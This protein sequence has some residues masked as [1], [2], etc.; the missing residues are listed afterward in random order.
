MIVSL[1]TDFGLSDEYAGLMKAVIYS[2]NADA[3]VVDLSHHV[4]AHDVAAASFLLASSYPFFP[5]GT[6]HVAVVDPGVG[7]S[8]RILAAKHNGHIFLAPD[9]GLL[10]VPL[11]EGRTELMV[12]VSNQSYF[13]KEQSATFHGRDIFAPVAAYLTRGVALDKLG[14]PMQPGKMIQLPG[15]L[16]SRRGKTIVGRVVAVDRFGNLVTNIPA[17]IV[18]DLV[19]ETGGVSP[20]V[21]VDG[22][23]VNGFY[24]SYGQAPENT[25]FVLVGSRGTLEVAVRERSAARHL[26]VEAGAMVLVEAE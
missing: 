5:P 15:V 26:N 23:P 2:I 7:T 10:T 14:P 12:S 11:S 3:K 13:L 1:L 6:V 22:T 8:R 4:P 21:A 9:N 25:P 24:A 20:S 18:R 16:A 19:D 17:G